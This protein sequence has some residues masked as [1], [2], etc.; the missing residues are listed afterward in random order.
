MK[1]DT[2]YVGLDVHAATIAVAVAEAGGEVR[3]LGEIPNRPEA[4]HKLLKRLGDPATLRICYEAG[5]TGYVLYWQLTK[6]GVHCEVIAPSLV[7]VKSGDRVKTDR[8]DAVRLARA[9]RAGDLTAVF[10]PD[11]EHEALR[12]LVRAREAAK[13]D[14]LRARH[15]VSKF[16]LRYGKYPPAGA[17]AWTLTWWRWL[18]TVKLEH[19][20]QNVTLLDYVN[21]L[22]HQTARV[23]RLEKAIDEAVEKAPEQMKAVVSALQSLRGVAKLTA[24]TLAVEV[25]SFRRFE[26]ATQLMS[27][28]GMVPS[29]R[30]SGTRERRGAITKAGNGRLRRVLVESAHHYR[31]QPRL[32]TRQRALQRDL[33][34]AVAEIA[35]KAQLR[36]HRRYHQLTGKTKPAG[37]VITALA[38]ELVGFIWA[39]G[40]A[41]EAHCQTRAAA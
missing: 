6:L 8:R 14:E 1:K 16:L 12:D 40:C 15:R 4:V 25:G 20:A 31:H 2:R 11:A 27:Y 13:T 33:N 29:E 38:R 18:R 3:S 37:K 26:R 28:T 10:V 36:L 7:P 34:P 41:A 30:S 22:E 9:L 5:P 23:E 35:W 21:E 17:R 19:A 24:I 39:I 32:S